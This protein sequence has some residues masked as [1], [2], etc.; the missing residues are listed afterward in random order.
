MMPLMG[1]R[2]ASPAGEALRPPPRP[3]P[4][5]Y[6]STRCK[7]RRSGGGQEDK[8][9]LTEARVKIERGAARQNGGFETE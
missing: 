9:G 7:A 5:F 6:K 4:L 3:L 8:K 2:F 1:A